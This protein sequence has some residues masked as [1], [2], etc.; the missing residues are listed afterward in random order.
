MRIRSATMIAIKTFVK[1]KNLN[2]QVIDALT[3]EEI[4][5]YNNVEKSQWISVPIQ[6]SIG[7]KV[8]TILYPE[9]P[10]PIFTLHLVIAEKAYTSIYNVLVKYKN[11]ETMLAHG[12]EIWSCNYE[13]GHSEV[14]RLAPNKVAFVVRN[15][16][17]LPESMKIST[18]AHIHIL[19]AATGKKDIQVV[20]ELDNPEEWRW[21]V[22]WN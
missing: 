16:P 11:I 12:A 4:E 8:A 10:N 1:E 17:A 5:I 20:P 6:A 15:F 21:I 13:D 22:S 9:N 14:L 2:Q 19:I 18:G 3:P 7:S